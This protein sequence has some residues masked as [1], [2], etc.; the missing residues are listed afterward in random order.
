VGERLKNSEDQ[1]AER[2]N[3][4]EEKNV[5]AAEHAIQSSEKSEAEKLRA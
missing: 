2:Q 1:K 3:N 4:R 5:R